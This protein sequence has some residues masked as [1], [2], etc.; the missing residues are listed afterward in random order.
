[1]LSNLVAFFLLGLICQTECHQLT[2]DHVI[3]KDPIVFVQTVWRHGS[4]TPLRV[5]I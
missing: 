2:D 3:S 1:M 4:R 5:R